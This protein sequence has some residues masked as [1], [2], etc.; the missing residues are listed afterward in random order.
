MDGPCST[1][2]WIRNENKFFCGKLEG[3]TLLGNLIVDNRI[4]LRYR[5]FH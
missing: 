1:H 3:K 2:E 4:I 5:D